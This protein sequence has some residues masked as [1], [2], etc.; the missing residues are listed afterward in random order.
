MTHRRR[1]AAAW[2]L[3]SLYLLTGPVLEAVHSEPACLS[4]G[5]GSGLALHAT[6]DGNR[7]FPV[8][9]SHTC[10][11]CTQLTQRITTPAVPYHLSALRP[12][13]LLAVPVFTGETLPVQYFSPDKRGP[14]P[15]RA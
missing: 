14:P 11:I 15:A 5:T 1:R 4:S 6:G 3:L 9:P 10:V 8:D 2:A 7:R 13:W 12:V